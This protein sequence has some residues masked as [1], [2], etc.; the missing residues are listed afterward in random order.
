MNPVADIVKGLI[1]PVTGLVSEF[2]EDKD[3]AAALAHEVATMASTQAHA[4]ALA[5]IE[6]NKVEAGHKSIFVAGWRPAIGWTCVI[7]FFLNFVFFPLGVFISVVI[8][9]PVEAPP[10]DMATMMPVLL[11]MLGLG[12]MRTIERTQGVA[13]AQ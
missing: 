5:Q 4:V 9:N 8:S 3:K 7:A 11:G 12:T 13:R 6:V 1:G 2:I 10:L